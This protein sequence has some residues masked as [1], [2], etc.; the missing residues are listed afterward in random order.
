MYLLLAD[1]HTLALQAVVSGESKGEDTRHGVAMDDTAMRSV[2]LG[3][4]VSYTWSS[5]LSAEAGVDVPV[6]V[7][8]SGEQVVPTW[9]ARAAL[10]WRF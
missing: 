6:S 9:R 1:E 8:S 5:R 10:S 2:Y 4:Q 3:P 7:V